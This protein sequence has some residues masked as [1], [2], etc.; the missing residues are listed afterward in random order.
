MWEILLMTGHQFREYSCESV[1][2]DGQV[3]KM[4]PELVYKAI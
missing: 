1:S 2:G 3:W 4:E